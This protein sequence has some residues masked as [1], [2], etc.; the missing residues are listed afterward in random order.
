MNLTRRDFAILKQLQKFKHTPPTIVTMLAR[1]QFQFWLVVSM[2]FVL[3][4]IVFTSDSSNQFG[5]L[6]LGLVSGILYARFRQAG[7]SVNVWHLS[8]EI[9]DW[10][11]VDELIRENERPT[12]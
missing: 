5:W 8:R 7:R 4:L 9:T 2:Y 11:R 10:K 3:L 6:V 1:T 12:A